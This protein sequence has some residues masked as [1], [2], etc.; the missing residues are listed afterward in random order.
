MEENE[1]ISENLPLKTIYGPRILSSISIFGSLIFSPVV[2]IIF[3]VAGLICS[4][5][6]YIKS[7]KKIFIYEI[8]FCA[9]ALAICLSLVIYQVCTLLSQ[10]TET[11]SSENSI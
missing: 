4:V 8:I 5:Y 6:L 1:P 10:P 11:I 7:K 9:I 3:S 2:F